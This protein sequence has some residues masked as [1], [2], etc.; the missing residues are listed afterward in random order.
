MDIEYNMTSSSNHSETEE[1]E[2]ISE[3]F[4]SFSQLI[5]LKRL[6]ED[7]LNF[8]NEEKYITYVLNDH[9]NIRR[10]FGIPMRDINQK[11]SLFREED[12]INEYRSMYYNTPFKE[13]LDH[14]FLIAEDFLNGIGSPCPMMNFPGN[15]F[16][17]ARRIRESIIED[18]RN[19]LLKLTKQEH[20][21]H[22]LKTGKI[23]ISN[24]VRRKKKIWK[25]KPKL[26][27]RHKTYVNQ[28][29]KEFTLKGE[30]ISAKKVRASILENFPILKLG[31]STV[32]Q[33]MKT[34]C[35]LSYKKCKIMKIGASSRLITDK[36]LVKRF[37]VAQF[38][39]DLF[40]FFEV[41]FIDE[42]YFHS[43]TTFYS[44]GPKG[45]SIDLSGPTGGQ[46]KIG[47]C[48]AISKQKFLGYQL[49]SD[50]KADKIMF[51]EFLQGL[52]TKLLPQRY[53]K[54]IVLFLDNSPVHRAKLIG[55]FCEQNGIKMIFNAPYCPDF[56]P[57]EN[58]FSLWKTK[59]YSQ[60][61]DSK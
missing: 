23:R 55:E 49:L 16:E 32:K 35:K 44:W 18:S 28:L 29:I 5:I 37:I 2:T 46:F 51:M 56:N 10:R 3:D 25:K 38:M 34:K 19:N 33:F 52:I 22:F 9:N 36:D 48:A 60:V 40:E 6:E 11:F 53:T 42:C 17:V 21:Q 14:K 13:L 8:Y 57:I 50:V 41:I 54:Q 45:E 15:P 61:F 26:D 59:T 39:L 47:V 7:D 58:L 30:K 43:N 4:A 1:E 24:E 20:V 12:F 31:L 27:E